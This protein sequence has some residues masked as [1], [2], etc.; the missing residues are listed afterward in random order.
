MIRYPYALRFDALN[1]TTHRLIPKH[2]RDQARYWY[3]HKV[4]GGQL[5]AGMYASQLALN[6]VGKYPHL[7]FTIDTDE[8]YRFPSYEAVKALSASG[9]TV[10][11]YPNGMVIPITEETDVSLD[12]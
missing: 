2:M 6:F 4:L 1:R 10:I 7:S 11:V 5:F 3:L 8:A 12:F 9:E